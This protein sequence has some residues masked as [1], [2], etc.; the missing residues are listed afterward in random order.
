MAKNTRQQFVQARLKAIGGEATPEQRVKLRQRF[1]VLSATKEGRTKI[2]KVILPDADA[3]TRAVLKKSLIPQTK[4]DTNKNNTG[5]STGGSTGSSTGGNTG[6]STGKSTGGNTTNT[7][8][9]TT[10]STTLVPKVLVTPTTLPTSTT[11]TTMA[12]N[13]TSTSTTTTIPSPTTTVFTNNASSAVVPSAQKTNNRGPGIVNFEPKGTPTV[14]KVTKPKDVVYGDQAA[15]KVALKL[16]KY[17]VPIFGRVAGIGRNLDAGKNKEAGLGL[18]NAVGVA[19]IA[20]FL[21]GAIGAAKTAKTVFNAAKS[22]KNQN[23]NLQNEF[24]LSEALKYE[25][26]AENARTVRR[27]FG[28]IAEQ[29]A[30][31]PPPGNK[32]FKFPSIKDQQKAYEYKPVKT[33]AGEPG[34]SGKNFSLDEYGRPVKLPKIK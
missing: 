31:N 12:K 30:G 33:K 22:L 10:T 6:G 24:R 3:K 19:A 29:R 26:T 8:G 23:T 32:D 4:V 1:D 28:T 17:D 7:I 34:T 13:N 9:S 16:E 27:D 15:E 25:R 20:R 5:G 2:A 14:K 11:S 21:P 18:L